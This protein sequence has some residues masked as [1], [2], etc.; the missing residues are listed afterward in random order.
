MDRKERFEKAYNYLK[1]KGVIK[2][3]EDVAKAMGATRAN[4][5]LALNGNPAVLTDNFLM[6]FTKAYSGTFN[7]DWLI[8]GE[9]E[10]LTVNQPQT[11]QEPSKSNYID[12]GSILNALL[13][14]KDET[15]AAM[16]D[17]LAA[18][19]E[20]I[21]AKDELIAA[22]RAQLAAMN[23]EKEIDKLGGYPR[24]RMASEPPFAPNR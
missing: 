24:D 2:K 15:I 11:Q 4:V 12:N 17:Q 10:M 23:Y 18:K 7:F 3:Q 22:L 21:Q 13:A 9:G 20:I 8:S 6:R 5:S 1:F 19:E 16:Q 14:A